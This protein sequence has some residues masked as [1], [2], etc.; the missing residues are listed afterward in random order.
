MV[1]EVLVRNAWRAVKKDLVLDDF[2]HSLGGASNN[3]LLGIPID[4][5]GSLQ[6]G[7]IL[8]Q[9]LLGLLNGPGLGRVLSQ[10]LLDHFWMLLSVQKGQDL[11]DLVTGERVLEIFDSINGEGGES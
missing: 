6:H 8:L 11:T 1:K 2:E 5:Q 10:E 3:G 9:N 7:R 4:N